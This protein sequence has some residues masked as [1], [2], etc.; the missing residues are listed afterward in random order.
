M[1]CN[2]RNLENGWKVQLVIPGYWYYYQLEIWKH[3]SGSLIFKLF[4]AAHL[5]YQ[6]KFSLETEDTEDVKGSSDW[7]RQDLKMEFCPQHCNQ[8]AE[9]VGAPHSSVSAWFPHLQIATDALLGRGL[10]WEAAEMTLRRPLQTWDTFLR[11][12]GR[13][14][15]G[16][17]HT[18]YNRWNVSPTGR[19]KTGTPDSTHPGHFSRLSV[20]ACPF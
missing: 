1:I 10:L 14:D 3:Y 18:W 16:C 9:W 17:P 4:K 15:N 12:R 7:R 5:Y 20:R 6:T 13:T 11:V 2:I 8:S 19:A